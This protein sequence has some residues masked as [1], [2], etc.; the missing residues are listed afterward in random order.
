MFQEKVNG[1][2]RRILFWEV[3]QTASPQVHH[4][5]DENVFKYLKRPTGVYKGK[6]N[7]KTKR[8]GQEGPERSTLNGRSQQLPR[9]SEQIAIC[10]LYS[11]VEIRVPIISTKDYSKT[12]Y[13]KDTIT[14][15]T[16]RKCKK[17]SKRVQKDPLYLRKL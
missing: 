17:N 14:K 4:I 8:Q 5:E 7:R 10:G 1:V 6:K 9:C 11:P 12:H 15:K 3:F 16:G 13:R 2:H